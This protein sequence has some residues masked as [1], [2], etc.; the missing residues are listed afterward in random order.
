L[1]AADEDHCNSSDSSAL[2]RDL[3]IVIRWASGNLGLPAAAALHRLISLHD[4]IFSAIART[5]DGVMKPTLL[6]RG[7]NNAT[8]RFKGLVT[9]HALS[10]YSVGPFDAYAAI[11]ESGALG[12][13]CCR[14]DFS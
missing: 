13:H 8:L 4:V 1:A 12:F 7:D 6:R 14:V 3:S 5:T 2:E 9:I 11:E 10:M